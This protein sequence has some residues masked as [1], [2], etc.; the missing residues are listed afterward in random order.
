MLNWFVNRWN[1]LIDIIFSVFL[2]VWNFLVDIFCFLFETIFNVVISLVSGLGTA[3]SSVSVP[4]YL[5][6]LPESML[7][8]MSIVGINEASVIIVTALIIR[9]TLQLIPFIRLGS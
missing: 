8:V 5:T 7:N 3:L 4:Q 9:F 6:F 1:D 2:D